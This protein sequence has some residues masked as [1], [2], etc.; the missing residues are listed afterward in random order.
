MQ[1]AVDITA[2]L[3]EVTGQAAQSVRDL[4]AAFD[5]ADTGRAAEGIGQLHQALAEL[6]AWIRANGDVWPAILAIIQ[7]GAGTGSREA[8]P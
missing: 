6:G 1:A 5:A 2:E 4:Q 3:A 7:A 8:S